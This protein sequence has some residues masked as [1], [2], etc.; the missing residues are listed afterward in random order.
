[1]SGAILA[2]VLCG[3]AALAVAAPFLPKRALKVCY[4]CYGSG[5]EYCHSEMRRCE[6]CDG[7]G[8]R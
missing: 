4:E 5:L 6:H 8:K 1:M 3:V 2:T 7:R